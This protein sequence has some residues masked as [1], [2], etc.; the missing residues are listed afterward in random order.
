MVYPVD[1]ALAQR[2]L[3]I[4]AP[5]GAYF[6]WGWF[7]PAFER[8]V[9]QQRDLAGC[10]FE[11][12]PARLGEAFLAWARIADNSTSFAALDEVDH[13][14]FLCGR[15]LGCLFRV[16]PLRIQRA[17][18]GGP[19]PGPEQSWPEGMALL[20]FVCTLLEAWLQQVR[21]QSLDWQAAQFQ[22]HWQSFREN[23]AED[24]NHA[25]P[26]LDLFTGLEPAWEDALAIHKRPAMLRVLAQPHSPRPA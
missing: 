11:V 22:R 18:A 19:V 2:W 21:G 16:R 25:G 4:R 12:D 20:T 7:L 6:R 10:D 17:A 9:R 14:H 13:A 3:A 26:F 24:A 23:V 5:A 15:L 8:C 1:S